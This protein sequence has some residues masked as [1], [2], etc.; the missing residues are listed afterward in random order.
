V[1]RPG[2]LGQHDRT[3]SQQVTDARL[4]R[5]DAVAGC[6]IADLGMV[7]DEAVRERGVSLDDNVVLGTLCTVSDGSSPMNQRIWLTLGS[8]SHA[9]RQARPHPEQASR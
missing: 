9:H 8:I 5:A 6:D 2:R 1:R 4:W 3:P 7:D